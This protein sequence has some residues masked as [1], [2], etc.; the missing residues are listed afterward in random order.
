MAMISFTDRF[1]IHVNRG[2]NLKLGWTK[3]NDWYETIYPSL[4]LISLC[5][6][7]GAECGKG[8]LAN[9]FVSRRLPPWKPSH[10]SLLGPCKN[11]GCS[12]RKVFLKIMPS[13]LQPG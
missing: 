12:V 8:V 5:L 9:D 4:D 6:L 7:T 3:Y 1:R 11:D 10:Q 2:T 13:Y